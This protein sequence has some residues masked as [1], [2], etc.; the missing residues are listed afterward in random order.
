MITT[1]SSEKARK[2]A[3]AVAA[4]GALALLAMV[5]LPASNFHSYGDTYEGLTFYCSRTFADE[6]KYKEAWTAFSTF[7][8]AGTPGV[9]AM[10]SFIS[11]TTPNTALQFYYFENIDAFYGQA[12]DEALSGNLWAQYTGTKETDYCQ[13]YG[14]WTEELKSIG[15]SIPG[16]HYS[17]QVPNGGFMRPA[18]LMASDAKDGSPIIFVSRREIKPGMMH[19][20]IK[21]FI[22]ASKVMFLEAP[23]LKATMSYISD[24]N[25]EIIWDLRLMTD[26][27]LGFVDHFNAVV[28]PVVFGGIGPTIKSFNFPYAVAFASKEDQAKMIAANPGNG[29]YTFYNFDDG[30]LLGPQPDFM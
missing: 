13:V 1:T 29:V 23:G 17:F 10:F 16:I 5:A 20:Y 4:M 24:D 15:N 22:D 25:P 21:G 9:K 19:Q 3:G 7:T 11:K 27:K 8:Q 28:A 18:E 12:K 6:A 2:V 26:F 30:S 14:A